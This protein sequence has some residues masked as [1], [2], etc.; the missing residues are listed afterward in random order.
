MEYDG[1]HEIDNVSGWGEMDDLGWDGFLILEHLIFDIFTRGNH[2]SCILHQAY[3]GLIPTFRPR[4]HIQAC[5][6]S[7]PL[8]FT[9]ILTQAHGQPQSHTHITTTHS[10]SYLCQP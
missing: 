2:L 5:S 7:V 1:S 9:P 3:S 10:V 6:L 4:T 8:S